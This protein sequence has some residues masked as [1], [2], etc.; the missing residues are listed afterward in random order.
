[1]SS[2]LFVGSGLFFVSYLWVPFGVAFPLELAGI[3]VT[4]MAIPALPAGQVIG[5]VLIDVDINHP[6]IAD[7]FPNQ[8]DL[9]LTLIG[10]AG[11]KINLVQNMVIGDVST[12]AAPVKSRAASLVRTQCQEPAKI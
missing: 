10:P 1:M 9:Q 5:E 12:A 4:S 2:S 3:F 11:Q 6:H 8:G 7:V